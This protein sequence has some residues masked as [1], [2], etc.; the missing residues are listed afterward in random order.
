MNASSPENVIITVCFQPGQDYKTIQLKT[1]FVLRNTGF[2]IDPLKLCIVS[3]WILIRHKVVLVMGQKIQI[4][5]NF[6]GYMDRMIKS[7]N[8]EISL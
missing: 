7:V 8:R 4:L 2:M 6:K 1:S 3:Q 5:S